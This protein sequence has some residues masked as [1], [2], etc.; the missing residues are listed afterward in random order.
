MIFTSCYYVCH[1]LP[2]SFV[3][4]INWHLKIYLVKC[5]KL[6]RTFCVF[7]VGS[8]KII[9]NRKIKIWSRVVQDICEKLFDFRKPSS[10]FPFII[11]YPHV[12]YF[13]LSMCPLFAGFSI[14]FTAVSSCLQWTSAFLGC[15][16]GYTGK[17]FIIVILFHDSFV[18]MQEEW[19]FYR[20]EKEKLFRVLSW[21]KQVRSTQLKWQK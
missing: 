11:I 7:R 16:S 5:K 15:S 14:I 1:F 6:Y 21:N 12:H 10:F 2:N 3:P 20:W 19:E 18:V 4:G 8:M 9:C 17:D 13:Y